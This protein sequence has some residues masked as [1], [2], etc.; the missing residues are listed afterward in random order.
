MPPNTIVLQLDL[1]ERSSEARRFARDNPQ[2]SLADLLGAYPAQVPP[3]APLPEAYLTLPLQTFVIQP[4]RV[5]GP[6]TTPPV[7]AA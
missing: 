7:P 3:D 4:V 1:G 5:T 6:A 2:L